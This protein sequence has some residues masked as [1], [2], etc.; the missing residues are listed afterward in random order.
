VPSVCIF[1]RQNYGNGPSFSR[2]LK[3]G[4]GESEV[5]VGSTEHS[6]RFRA[7]FI[8]NIPISEYKTMSQLLNYF[9]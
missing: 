3:E 1:L 9:I 8:T 4:T 6:A 5:S 2:K 7:L